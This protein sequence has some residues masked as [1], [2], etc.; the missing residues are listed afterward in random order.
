[1]K[2]LV[3][4]LG[5]SHDFGLCESCWMNY[6][7]IYDNP[8]V[9]LWADKIIFPESS[10]NEQILANE[11]KSDGAVNLILNMAHENNII[12]L[13]DFGHLF[14]N[15]GLDF[16]SEAKQDIHNILKGFPSEV[17]KDEQHGS[18]A[19]I[20]I[21]D[22]PYCPEYVASI[23]ASTY[24]GEVLN[25]SCLYSPHDYEFLKYKND[26]INKCD[27]RV[28]QVFTEIFSLSLPNEFLQHN[29]AFTSDDMCKRCLKEMNCKNSYLSDIEKRMK[30]I[31]KIRNTDEMQRAKEELQKVIE[32]HKKY[33]N[34]FSPEEIKREFENV[35]IKINKKLKQTFP[36]IQRWTN[37]TTIASTAVAVGV[38][39]AG[40]IPLGGVVAAAIAGTHKVADEYMKYY[41]NKNKWVGFINENF[42]K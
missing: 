3:T 5:I 30:N 13:V 1:M 26:Y 31:I 37:L 15:E 4:G 22:F 34:D 8:S 25:A 32:A 14:E 7:W 29:Y 16:L 27:N 40:D 38:A 20:M 2:V 18:Q 39:A 36:K 9:L 11:K 19:E 33:S 6:S 21:K 10:Y 24:I 42:D 23:N 41:T 35:Q 28:K 17:T 12:E